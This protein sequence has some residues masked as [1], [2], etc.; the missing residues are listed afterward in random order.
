MDVEEGLQ[1]NVYILTIDNGLFSGSS[2][3]YGMLNRHK[4]VYQLYSAPKNKRYNVGSIIYQP[5]DMN[6]PDDRCSIAFHMVQG[7]MK[8]LQ[9]NP[10][11]VTAR[12][13]LTQFS[14][15]P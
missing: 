6:K 7:A 13:N 15:S 4:R 8:S 10:I 11:P 14:L 5:F 2:S 9:K 12:P 1:E 3:F